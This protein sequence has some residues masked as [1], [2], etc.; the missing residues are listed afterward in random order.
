MKRIAFY[1]KRL[2]LPF[3]TL[4]LCTGCGAGKE[5]EAAFFAMDTYMTIKAYGRN[6]EEAVS[7]AERAVFD[8]ENRISR[9][10]EGTDISRLNAADGSMIFL[11]ADTL[12]ILTV[13]KELTVPGVFDVTICAV[14][15][16]WGIGSETSR[17]PSQAEID[18]ALATVGSDNLTLFAN[19]F[20]QLDNGAKVDLG[21]IGKGFAADIC[22][23]LLREGGVKSA[24]VYLG[25]NIYA[26][27]GKPDGSDWTVG[28]ADPDGPS[29]YIATIEAQDASVVTTGDYE[30]YFM[31]DGVRYHHVMDPK[32]GAPARSGL[33]SVT[34]VHESSTVADARSTTLFVLGLEK[35]LEYCAENGL[36]AVFITEDKEIYVTGGLRDRFTFRGEGTGYVMAS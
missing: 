3:L 18:G 33:R 26:L 28:I 20:A 12:R 29:D 36:E 35:G 8:L 25:G 32:T 13:A 11:S 4:L 23:N 34:V 19:G 1:G 9:T 27:G 2:L 6:A 30:R 16:L 21:A 31:R 5:Y 17:V 10:R 14:S 7:E 15:D 22:V 24:L